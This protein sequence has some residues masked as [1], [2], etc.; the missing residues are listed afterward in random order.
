MEEQWKNIEGFPYYQVSNFGRVKS[1]KNGK[2]RILKPKKH[3]TGYLHIALFKNGKH[4]WR[5]I[6]RLVAEAFLPNPNNLSDVNHKDENPQNSNLENL[7]WVDHKTNIN[8]GT[9]I[10]RRAKTQTNHQNS[11]TVFQ[12][13]LDGTFIR[14]WPSLKEV[15]RQLG[16]NNGSIS[17]CCLGKCKTSYG[18]IWK[19]KNEEDQK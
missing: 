5:L 13:N 10:E 4:Y 7:E 16:F 17:A 8:Y 2:E 14:E 11:K 6:H 18:F 1:L 3:K 15:Q 9:G 12:Y 19:Y